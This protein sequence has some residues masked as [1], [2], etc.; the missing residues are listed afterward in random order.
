MPRCAH[1]GHRGRPRLRPAWLA[2]LALLV[3]L[4]PLAFLS[5]GYWPFFLLPAIAISAWALGAVRRHC[6]RCGRPWRCAP[7]R[8]S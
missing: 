6:P 4:L 1:C 2:W 8:G 3:W 5:L 7:P